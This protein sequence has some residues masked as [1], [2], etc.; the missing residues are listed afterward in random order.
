MKQV[1]LR[2][3]TSRS[4]SQNSPTENKF[5]MIIPKSDGTQKFTNEVDE[6]RAIFGHMLGAFG[7]QIPQNNLD[8]LRSLREED[9]TSEIVDP[10]DYTGSEE[11]E[12]L[13]FDPL[14]LVVLFTPVEVNK[15]LLESLV[16]R[17][18]VCLL[19]FLEDVTGSAKLTFLSLFIGV[20]A[21]NFLE[22]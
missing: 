6:L 8:N 14:A 15:G 22:T 18:S 1:C 19:M 17:E 5:N 10:P 20:T 3:A 11:L 16:L 12:I 7:V 13:G 4:E 2:K 9:G 21:T